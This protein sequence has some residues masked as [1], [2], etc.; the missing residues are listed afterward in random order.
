M[1]YTKTNWQDLPNTTTPINATNLNKMENGIADANGAIGV[2]AYDS[3]ATYN[4][5]DMC[6]YN[7]SLY[8]C[9]TQ[10]STAESFN[11]SHWQQ[12]SLENNVIYSLNENNNIVTETNKM[13]DVSNINGA[14]PLS[15]GTITGTLN[16]STILPRTNSNF[17]FGNSNYFWREIFLKKLTSSTW[18]QFSSGDQLV[19]GIDR[20]LVIRSYLDIGES[21][22]IQASSFN[23]WS[24]RRYKKNIT[25][26]SEKEADKILDVNVVNFDYKNEK[27]GTNIAGVIAEDVYDILPNV[28]TLTEINGERVPDSVDYSKFVPYLIKKVQMLQEEVQQLKNN[29]N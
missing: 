8:I 21:R 10:I 5:K 16:A 6:I 4:V 17:D 20:E 25:E 27:N 12:L 9:T 11:A 24:S 26:L 3:T 7:N 14:L 23:V 18:N 13:I 28:V 1:S 2:D 15:G 22:P 19:I 29:N